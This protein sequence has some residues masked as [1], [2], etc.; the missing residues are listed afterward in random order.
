MS[1]R[2]TEMRSITSLITVLVFLAMLVI[3][4]YIYSVGLNGIFLLDDYSNIRPAIIKEFSW[5]KLQIASLSNSS[6][7][8]KR[9]L[10]ALSFAL[11]SIAHGDQSWGFKYHNVLIHLLLALL[12]FILIRQLCLLS[13]REDSK[14][15]LLTPFFVTAIW[16][17]HPLHVSTVLYAVQRMTQLSALFTVLALITYLRTRLALT[18]NKKIMGYVFWFPIFFT[19]AILSKENA[20]LLVIYILLLYIFTSRSIKT[21]IPPPAFIDKAFLTFFSILP[22]ISAT[23]ILFIKRDSLLD[24]STRSFD[25]GERLLSQ[26][27]FIW[28]YIMQLLLP[29]L[30]K[31][32]LYFDD[33]QISDHLTFTISVKL[34]GLTILLGI[35]IYY[36]LK[37]KIYGLG[38]MFFFTGHALESTIFPLELAFEHRN[39]LPSVGIFIAL[40]ALAL[41]ILRRKRTL[42]PIGVLTTSLLLLLLYLRVSFWSDAREWERTS[43]AFHPNSERT[44]LNYM[45]SLT[46]AGKLKLAS[47]QGRK[48]MS[49]LPEKLS[50]KFKYLTD[51]CKTT[52]EDPENID[53]ID[54][55]YARLKTDNFTVLG[56][57][58]LSVLTQTVIKNRCSSISFIQVEN[59]VDTAL[60]LSPTK[61]K[62]ETSVN[63]HLW[64]LKGLLASARGSSFEASEYFRKS[65]SQSNKYRQKLAEIK[66]LLFQPETRDAGI[67]ILNRE[68]N[69]NAWGRISYKKELE[70]IKEKIEKNEY[71]FVY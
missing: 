63:S 52:T 30:S 17:I 55:I 3:T 4:G 38:I 58:S 50:L 62:K 35:G 21:A 12:I 36:L 43:L 61:D 65:Y 70:T 53:I 59:I 41:E 45:H 47:E 44:Q 18:L 48:A 23:F 19:T 56:F 67:S 68:L 31:M 42:I 8:L 49:I 60:F 15:A 39:Y 54:D 13:Y 6:G 5:E 34:I 37:G 11:T 28:L 64:F 22:I 57:N 7:P 1:L 26:I 16:L 71:V 66:A 9:P 20:V 33:F 14:E 46:R 69:N 24:Y 27:D 32:G 40:I 29:R 25:L 2:I 10:S 51:S